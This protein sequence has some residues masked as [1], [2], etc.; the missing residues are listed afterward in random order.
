MVG[1][2]DV[3]LTVTIMLHKQRVNG[4]TVATTK[5]NELNNKKQ[6]DMYGIHW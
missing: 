2:G 4:R 1:V 5:P 3:H 6:S